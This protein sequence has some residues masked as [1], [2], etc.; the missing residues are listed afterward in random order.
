MTFSRVA[1][2]SLPSPRTCRH[3]ELVFHADQLEHEVFLVSA[4]DSTHVDTTE[5]VIARYYPQ[6]ELRYEN[7]E[8]YSSFVSMEKSRSLLGF[9]PRYSWRNFSGPDPLCTGEI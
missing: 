7:I 4:L 3:N 2:Y 8:P 9:V 5:E 1:V 6:A